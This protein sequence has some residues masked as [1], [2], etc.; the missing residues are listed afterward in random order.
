[1]E[2]INIYSDWH[3]WKLFFIWPD[4]IYGRSRQKEC[5]IRLVG[6]IPS[7]ISITL[8]TKS[9]SVS[10]KILSY[11]PGEDHNRIKTIVIPEI[12]DI[13]IRDWAPVIVD[14]SGTTTLVKAIYRPQY[15]RGKYEKYA[16]G[17]DAAGKKLASI[18]GFPQLNLPL[19]WDIGNLTHNGR[20]TAIVTRRILEDNP[21]YDETGIRVLFRE[22]LGIDKLLFMEVE[23]GDVTG[24]VDGTV[25]FLDKHYIAIAEYPVQYCRENEWLNRLVGYIK[26]ELG[27]DFTI[28]RIPNGI[29]EN[30]Q[31]E[32]VPSAF[33]NHLN[34]IRVA[35]YLLLPCY[36][37]LEDELAMNIIKMACPNIH[38]IPV[39]GKEVADLSRLGGVL[40]CI[41]WS[42]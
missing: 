30:A 18:L 40:N 42:I 14:I 38:V 6:M 5:I 1:M 16:H 21:E 8:L 28:V 11:F 27:S 9:N 34:F 41:S 39:D 33:G 20:G 22:K 4:G 17:D 7:D 12:Q 26:I 31:W 29:I 19:V 25:R 13:W 37:S 10:E 3:T 24:H 32:G 35:D 2:R 15:L 23:P 36:G